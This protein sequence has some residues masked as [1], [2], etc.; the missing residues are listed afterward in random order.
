M[1]VGEVTLR[2]PIESI[3]NEV[4]LAEIAKKVLNLYYLSVSCR[5]QLFDLSDDMVTKLDIE[6]YQDCLDALVG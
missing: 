3:H 2:G 6:F 4:N 5:H 1:I